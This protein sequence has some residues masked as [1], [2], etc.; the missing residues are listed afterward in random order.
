MKKPKVG[1][2]PLYI[3]L[4]DKSWPEM[5]TR[6]D[7]F[8]QQIASALTE[9]GLEVDTV[10][11]CRVKPEFESAIRQFERK[12][13][14]AIV[15]LH[16]A[17]SPSLE[18]SAL[19]ASTPLPIVVLDSTPTYSYGPGQDPE[20]LLYNHG[21][22]GV[23]DMCNL[24]RRN[25]KPY[26]VVEGHWQKSD[27]L[28]RVAALARGA[29]LVGALKS[30]RVGQLGPAFTGMGDF[31]VTPAKLK[32]TLGI[33]TIQADSSLMRS[34]LSEVSDRA[35]EAEMSYDRE[36]FLVKDLN[37]EVHRL[38]TRAGLVIRRWIEKE[39]LTAFTVNF[40]WVDKA[41]GLPAMP[42]L[43]ASKAMARGVGYAGEGDVLTAALVGALESVYPETSFIEM[44]C[45]DW[46][47][48]QLFLSHMGEMNIDLTAATPSLLEKPFPF[49]DI[50]NP[51]VAVGR[52]RPGDAVLVNL[53][54][55]PNDTYSLIV[56]PIV[57]QDVNGTDTMAESIHGW[58][59]ASMPVGDFLAE[60]SR[61]GG[62]HHSG[63]VYG[64]AADSI[65]SWGSL[66][67]WNPVL[68]H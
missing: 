11:V 19:L 60:Y 2:L 3:E 18:S 13:V 23:Q 53:A 9:H 14:D 16:L 54:P 61:S 52:Y 29:Q 5:R 6:V 27:V 50:G 1:L 4:Y 15:T 41:S 67:G 49:T 17:Y 22:H 31:A 55:G 30:A 7:G 44:F 25:Q 32:E 51:A 56:A 63:L 28:E 8:Y 48:D 12:Q 39:R 26:G 42:F 46:E 34:L 58:F 35:V 10:P 45:P 62:T 24:L 68:L 40:L 64:K 21:I 57:M 20:E 37:P 38:T 65:V 66:M 47:G 36:H 59:K 43:E 33:E